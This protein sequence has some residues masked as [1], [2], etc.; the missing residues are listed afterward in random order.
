M[1]I[2]SRKPGESV[3]IGE[4]IHIRILEIRGESVKIGI[5]AP[6]DT[7]VHRREVYDAI[8]EENRAASNVEKDIFGFLPKKI[9]DT[10]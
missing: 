5:E 10:E 9:D 4:N 2:L 6:R 8:L 1:L 3:V 7:A